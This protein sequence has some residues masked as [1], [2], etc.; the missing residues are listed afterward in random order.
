[1]I[2]RVKKR[3]TDKLQKAPLEH[4]AMLFYNL[5]VLI[6]IKNLLKSCIAFLEERHGLLLNSRK[7]AV[8]NTAYTKA[9][10]VLVEPLLA[11]NR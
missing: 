6:F 4:T 8:C 7:K 11:E 2:I 5:S 10:E 1:M 3:Y 9:E